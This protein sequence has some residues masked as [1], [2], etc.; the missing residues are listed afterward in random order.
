MM[1][2]FRACATVSELIH[3]LEITKKEILE[4]VMGTALLLMDPQKQD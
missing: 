2:K 3:G 4:I 1:E